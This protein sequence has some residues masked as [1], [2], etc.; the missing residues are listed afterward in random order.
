MPL[1]EY[2]YD[3]PQLGTVLL[4]LVAAFLSLFMAARSPSARKTGARVVAVALLASLST[5]AGGPWTLSLGLLT[6]A[7][8]DALL[9]QDSERALPAVLA[10][11]IAGHLAYSVMLI[12]VVH[13]GYLTTHPLLLLP[14]V[15]ALVAFVRAVVGI[16]RLTS[17]LRALALVYLAMALAACFIALATP[18]EGI[19]IGS[20]LL[21]P[22][23][24]F[25]VHLRH[26]GAASASIE[27]VGWAVFYCAHLLITLSALALI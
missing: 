22:Y 3:S 27:T 24:F 7:A 4:S 5:I 23:A 25:V 1:L 12:P 8:A 11:L 10:C 14:F 16:G 26:S 6:F 21:L 17:G 9:V 18:R 13:L 15:L 20:L 19:A 2:G